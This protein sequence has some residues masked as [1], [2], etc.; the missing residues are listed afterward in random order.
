MRA[1][2]VAVSAVA[3][4]AAFAVPARGQ[5]Y[6]LAYIDSRRLLAEAPGAQEAQQKFQD[7]LSAFR[8]QVQV[9]QDSLNAMIDDYQRKS[10]LL[11]PEEKQRQEDA[12]VARRDAVQERV[13]GIDARAQQRQN[14]LMAPVMNRIQDVIDAIRVEGGYSI[15]F[16]AAQGIVSA[17]TTLDMTSN[18]LARM[19]ASAGG[20][21][22]K[23]P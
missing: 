18:V 17:D 23:R 3:G 10:V 1:L 14:E 13:N 15:I 11:S 19:N 20:Q 16:D 6:K 12:I 4:L 9:L 21:T 7:E 5:V 8:A 2:F 22:S